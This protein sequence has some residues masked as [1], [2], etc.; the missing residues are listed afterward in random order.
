[1]KSHNQT[2]YE[3]LDLVFLQH[4]KSQASNNSKVRTLIIQIYSGITSGRV[5][6]GELFCTE[7]LEVNVFAFA[8]RLF[9]EDFLK[10]NGEWLIEEKS[11]WNS[12]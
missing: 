12:L 5:V 9:Q 6:D 1:M 10:T 4:S 7:I 11:S 3:P 2:S 8:Y